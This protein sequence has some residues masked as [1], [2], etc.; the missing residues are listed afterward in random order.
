MQKKIRWVLVIAAV[1]LL[2]AGLDRL[3]FFRLPPDRARITDVLLPPPVKFN[4][5]VTG[6][7]VAVLLLW[8]LWKLGVRDNPEDR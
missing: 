4:L 5:I 7:G 6:C 3:G 2:S 8:V 1:L